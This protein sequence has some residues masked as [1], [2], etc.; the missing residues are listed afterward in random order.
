I[1]DWEQPRFIH[2][3]LGLTRDSLGMAC[4]H[5]PKFISIDRGGRTEILPILKYD[6]I[7][8]VVPPRNGEIQ[9]WRARELIYNLSDIGLPIKWVT[10]DSY[11]SV[12]SIQ[13]L[14]QRGYVTGKQSMDMDIRAYEITKGAFYDG[15]IIA[16]NHVKGLQELVSL[17][18]DVKKGKIDHPPGGSK[19]VADAIAGVAFGLTSRREVWLRHNINPSVMPMSLAEVMREDDEALHVE[20]R[21]PLSKNVVPLRKT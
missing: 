9:F 2:N 19:D 21:V 13:V 12:D 6:F 1:Q 16:P 15:R 4:G 3:D 10:F 18:W 11:Q 5:V 7:L 20:K 14:R 8:E 17:E